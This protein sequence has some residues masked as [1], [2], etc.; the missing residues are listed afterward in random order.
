MKIRNVFNKGGQIVPFTFK[1]QKYLDVDFTHDQHPYIPYQTLCFWTRVW[2]SYDTQNIQN[3]VSIFHVSAGPTFV[4][5][6]LTIEVFGVTRKRLLQQG[7]TNTITYDFETGQNLYILLADRDME[8]YILID[9][10]SC[11]PLAT[12]TQDRTGFH[13]T[14]NSYTKLAE[15]PEKMTWTRTFP[16]PQ[17]RHQYIWEFPHPFNTPAA[18][19]TLMPG[20]QGMIQVSDHNTITLQQEL[21]VNKLRAT[22]DK[23]YTANTVQPRVSYP[24]LNMAQPRIP[25]ETGFMKFR[26]AT[27]MSAETRVLFHMFPDYIGTGHKQF[28]GRQTLPLPQTVATDGNVHHVPCMPYEMHNT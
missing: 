11:W 13:A 12:H 14:E 19:T 6:E 28:W 24:R 3:A 15:I 23:I 21:L 8:T 26:Y 9:N 16:W 20:A 25:D 18:Y 4:E 7:T 22:D 2:D 1:W 10:T 27:R 17:L 5:S